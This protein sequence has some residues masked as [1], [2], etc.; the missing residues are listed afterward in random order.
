MPPIVLLEAVVFSLCLICFQVSILAK[1]IEKMKEGLKQKL[2][3]R[4]LT[5]R[6]ETCY[7]SYL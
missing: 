3:I 4:I 2:N 7:G 6:K 5:P 1:F